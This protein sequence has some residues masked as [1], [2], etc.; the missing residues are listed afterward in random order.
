M[1]A[2]E[3]CLP[4]TTLRILNETSELSKGAGETRRTHDRPA[5][6]DHQ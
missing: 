3:R 5:A 1:P 2:P 6:E 4:N